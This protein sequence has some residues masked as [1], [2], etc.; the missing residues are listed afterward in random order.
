MIR[1]QLTLFVDE[2]Q[3]DAIE[4]IRK[5]FNPEQFHL[6]KSHV[7]LCREDELINIEMVLNNLTKII[8]GPLTIAFEKVCRF[9]DGRGVWLPASNHNSSFQDL[10]SIVLKNVVDNPKKHI[11]HITLMHPRNSICTDLIFE[12]IEKVN[13][14]ESITFNQISL[15][16]QHDGKQWKILKSFDFT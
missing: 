3:S 8:C 1:R 15:I 7:T 6:I 10:R 14:P 9:Q 13:F 12:Q 16:E 5:T 2:D 11:P 4:S